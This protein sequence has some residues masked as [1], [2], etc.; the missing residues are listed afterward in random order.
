MG[1]LRTRKR[2]KNWEYSF[3]A[4][5]IDG[6]RKSISKGGFRTKAEA[7][8]AGT[9]A[10]AE[11]NNTGSVFRSSDMSLSDYMDFWIETHVKNHFSA[12]TYDSYSDAIRNHIKPALGIYKLS[13]LTP[14]MIQSWI[15]ALKTEKGLSE[16]SIANY[17]GV[18]SGALN[19]AVHPCE[20]L[21]QN[22][23]SY[24]HVPKVPVPQ[25]TK[26]HTEY[27]CSLEEWN[28][29]INYFYNNRD[30]AYYTMLIILY[31]TGIRAGE[32]C[33]IDLR[34]DVDFEKHTLSIQR[35]MQGKSNDWYLVPPKYNSVRTLRIGPTLENAIKNFIKKEEE[36]RVKYGPYYLKTYADKSGH[37]TQL[38]ASE[39]APTD[40]IEIY[41]IAKENG[42]M[43]TLN[44]TKYI[45]RTVKQKLGYPFFHVHSLRHT[46]GTILAE[47]GASPKTIMERLGHKN[48]KVTMERYV[49][50]T[51]AMQDAAVALFEKATN[52]NLS[53]AES[54]VDKR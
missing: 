4:A 21:K 3:E 50:N 28:N 15:N 34:R 37:L 38:P 1:T 24:T 52:K 18:L 20:Y 27:V 44:V 49:F 47:N 31:H 30:I 41:P 22:P 11:Y 29:I 25:E 14:V 13:S 26:A 39:K 51:E 36:N 45:S 53:T 19:Y 10:Q 35:Q 16:Q 43:P 9:K 40:C 33:G 32:C 23:C 46:H 2:G 12:N 7:L 48:I 17:R 42:S 5:K 6:K 8:E 54:L